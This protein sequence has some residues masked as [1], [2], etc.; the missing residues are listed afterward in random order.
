[1]GFNARPMTS[2]FRECRSRGYVSQQFSCIHCGK[3]LY[4]S[5]TAHLREVHQ[6]KAT[7]K[8]ELMKHV[9]EGV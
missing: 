7:T 1:M 9:K 8:D 4:G 2:W 6:I 5:A 3:R